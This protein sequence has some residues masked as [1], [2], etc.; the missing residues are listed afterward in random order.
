MCVYIY[1]QFP[2]FLMTLHIYTHTHM[3]F[4]TPLFFFSL[5]LFFLVCR[6]RWKNLW[7]LT[8]KKKTN[9]KKKIWSIFK[10]KG[11]SALCNGEWK[12]TTI[13]YL[14]TRF[15]H[16]STRLIVKLMNYCLIQEFYKYLIM[17][18][19]DSNICIKMR[20][21]GW[22]FFIVADGIKYGSANIVWR[23]STSLSL[24]HSFIH[25]IL[26]SIRGCLFLFHLR[27]FM[28]I[29]LMKHSLSILLAYGSFPNFSLTSYQ[30]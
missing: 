19:D 28:I 25:F 10:F 13:N 8:K 23:L 1:I 15:S 6:A 22:D 20:R 26:V 7:M 17:R 18:H 2:V 5:S 24:T 21:V 12:W 14:Y 29:N 16:R 27:K 4:L 30:W 9:K 11:F 3:I